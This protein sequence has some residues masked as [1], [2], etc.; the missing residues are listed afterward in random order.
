MVATNDF[1]GLVNSVCAL[2]SAAVRQAIDSLDRC[3]AALLDVQVEGYGTRLRAVGP[4][5]M[6]DRFFGTLRH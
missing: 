6:A 4:D 3:M 5:A 1:S 2:A